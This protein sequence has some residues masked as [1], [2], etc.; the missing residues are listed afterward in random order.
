VF[1]ITKLGHAWCCIA[2]HPRSRTGASPA[3]TDFASSECVIHF[4]HSVVS[5]RNKIPST[6]D[7]AGLK[8][9][10][11]AL[12]P[13]FPTH[14]SDISTERTGRTA[15]SAAQ[16]ESPQQVKDLPSRSPSCCAP[17]CICSQHHV[18]STSGLPP[19][20]ARIASESYKSIW[21]QELDFSLGN[22]SNMRVSTCLA[23]L[24]FQSAHAAQSQSLTQTASP[25]P[26]RVEAATATAAIS[27]AAE[28]QTIPTAEKQSVEAS[29]MGL[30]V[31]S[32]AG[33]F[34]L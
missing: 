30:I 20:T 22:S 9:K 23:A 29:L 27:D 25:I 4:T 6:L 33:L 3:T 24:A 15:G 19:E 21:A 31:F 16:R 13:P 12:A 34:L 10:K 8:H 1:Q 32:A 26:E 14:H 5:F 7:R 18:P 11:H 28:F 2:I 17:P